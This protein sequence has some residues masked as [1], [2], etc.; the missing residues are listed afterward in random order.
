MDIEFEFK[1]HNIRLTEL[2]KIGI[3]STKW[4][5]EVILGESFW[6]EFEFDSE[7][8][9]FAKG[10]T[11]SVVALVVVF[12]FDTNVNVVTE[13]VRRASILEIKNDF[14]KFCKP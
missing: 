8:V 14:C 3:R 2:H 10:F 7:I 6:S 4:L 11:N 9:Y 13:E 12:T 1:H 5:E